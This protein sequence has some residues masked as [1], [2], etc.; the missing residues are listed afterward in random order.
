MPINQI[1][2]QPIINNPGMEYGNGLIAPNGLVAPLSPIGANFT[3]N[4]YM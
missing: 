2:N 1:F 4:G 3:Q